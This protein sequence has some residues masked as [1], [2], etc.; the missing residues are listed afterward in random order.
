MCVNEVWSVWGKKKKM[1][2]VKG[3]GFVKV[4]D[5]G[6]DGFRESQKK[7]MKMKNN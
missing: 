4:R 5:F 6:G 3:E 7:K 2:M 1:M